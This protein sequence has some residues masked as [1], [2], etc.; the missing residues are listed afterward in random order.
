MLKG[1]GDG[2]FQ[3]EQSIST[4]PS[5]DPS[6]GSAYLQL[7]D[8]NKD[9]K[10]DLVMTSVFNSGATV[11]IGNGDGTFQPPKC[12]RPGASPTSSRPRM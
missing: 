4:D 9:G 11:L 8:V 1:N 5:F 7:L 2:T 12:L 3:T 6:L 10:L